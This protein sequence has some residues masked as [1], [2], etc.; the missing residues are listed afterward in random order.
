MK[1]LVIALA[2]LCVAA[3]AR[4][5]NDGHPIKFDV[6]AETRQCLAL[7]E[8][9]SQARDPARACEYL[10]SERVRLE[11]MRAGCLEDA[12]S[13]VFCKAIVDR[14]VE[15]YWPGILAKALVR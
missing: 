4:A 6:E 12:Q 7:P 2:L 8:I 5:G 3:T 13:P 10:V 9:K 1:T 15:E 11:T 14:Y